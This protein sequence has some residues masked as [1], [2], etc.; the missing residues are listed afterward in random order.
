[1]VIL[2]EYRLGNSKYIKS[3]GDTEILECPKCKEKV[4]F[5]VFMNYERRLSVENM[6]DCNNVYFLVCPKCTSF[7]TVDESKGDNFRKGE[8]L[9]IGNFDLKDLKKFK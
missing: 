8:N 3:G 7:F 4:R 6:I 5:G 9:S 2:M 1:M